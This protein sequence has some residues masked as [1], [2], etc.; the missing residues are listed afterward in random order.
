ML[1]YITKSQQ[2]TEENVQQAKEI[3]ARKWNGLDGFTAYVKEGRVY[4]SKKDITVEV[5][6]SS[7][8]Y[9][10]R[11][12]DINFGGRAT[13]KTIGRITPK[14]DLSKSPSNKEFLKYANWKIDEVL[15]EQIVA[16]AKARA[17]KSNTSVSETWK[18]RNADF[19]KF[20]AVKEVEQAPNTLG[21][22]LLVT[23]VKSYTNPHEKPTLTQLFKII[24]KSDIEVNS[25]DRWEVSL[26]GNGEQTEKF[27]RLLGGNPL[28]W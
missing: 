13:Y 18:K 25:I 11:I 21:T 23:K 14:T 27:V 3:L 8:G 6:L 17:E 19:I 4:I 16:P 10:G 7:V 12:L 15:S 2:W 9:T 24:A 20:W 26:V 1:S 22:D 5:R 28:D